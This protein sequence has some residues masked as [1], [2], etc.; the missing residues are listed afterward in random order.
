[1]ELILQN[2]GIINNATIKI[3]GLTV[4]C[5][6]NN[7]GKS[8]VGKALYATIESL[9]NLE[10]KIHDELIMNYRRT[11]SSI[12]RLLDLESVAKYVDFDR[13]QEV[14]QK[15]L[16]P[17]LHTSL[18][19]R[20]LLE[21][22]DVVELFINLKEIVDFITPQT[23]LDFSIKQ[24][25]GLPKK[26]SVFLDNYNEN[27][28][29]A[30]SVLEEM[31]KYYF[32]KDLQG[33]A[34]RSV[35][36]LFNVEF[37]G[38][39]YPINLKSKEKKS[40][41]LITKNGEMGSHFTL[42]EKKGLSANVMDSKLFL[43]NA[44]YVEDPYVL[45]KITDDN[46]PLM[47]RYGNRL[48]YSHS[49]KLNRL[50]LKRETN[51]IIEQSINRDRYDD[52]INKISDIIPGVLTIR[53]SGMY[54]EEPEKEPLKVQNLATGSKMFS[55]I[56]NLLEKGEINFDTMLILDEPEAHLH[57]AWQNV[58][59]EVIVLL[60]KELGT[61]ILLTTH[62]PNFLMALEAYSKKYELL[63][64]ANYYMAKHNDSKYMVDYIC[65]NGRISEIYSSFAL[66]L[67]EVKKIKDE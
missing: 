28:D 40:T 44:I 3:K 56:K 60:V 61:N 55:I 48:D 4:I 62:S 29:R 37:N 9:S 58:F 26:F 7:S 63:E 35:A 46:L 16:S 15:D 39:V 30:M 34:E 10:E 67:V 66:P 6:N 57:P 25:N 36:S 32:D 33:F 54:Y 65:V 13:M 1:M 14:L 12:S 64:K 11:I 21:Y 50:L 18:G 8:T 27:R 2:I 22:V 23:L 47:Y 51:S 49:A 24:K 31:N 5:G 45:D 59:A 43:H 41:V 19:Y 20:R 52:I 42:I 38:Q 17:L 53:E